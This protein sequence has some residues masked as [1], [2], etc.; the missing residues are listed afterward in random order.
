M[1]MGELV[2][3]ATTSAANVEA[4]QRTVTDGDSD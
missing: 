1:N 3:I 4:L 2:L